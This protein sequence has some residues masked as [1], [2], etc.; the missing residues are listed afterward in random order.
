M[1]RT[2][3]A[4]SSLLADAVLQNLK[5]RKSA[6][7]NAKFSR[8]SISL[9]EYRNLHREKFEEDLV[10]MNIDSSRELFFV[11]LG[12]DLAIL[13]KAVT[14]MIHDLSSKNEWFIYGLH[15]QNIGTMQWKAL[16]LCLAEKKTS[17]CKS[18]ETMCLHKFC[19]PVTGL[20]N[21]T[22]LCADSYPL[23]LYVIHL[24]VGENGFRKLKK[25]AAYG[26]G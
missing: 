17:Q 1:V 11:F 12:K 9:N 20:L 6:D 13:S 16:S 5:V 10:A 4:E 15:F 7:F 19:F 26:K 14:E 2:D 21:S 24:A 22:A 18:S 8:I 3:D 25:A 23:L